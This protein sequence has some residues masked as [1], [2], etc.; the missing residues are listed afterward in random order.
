M[1]VTLPM[2]NHLNEK[3]VRHGW[4]L[5]QRDENYY[6]AKLRTGI[7]SVSVTLTPE[8]IDVYALLAEGNT[9][10][11]TV[12]LVFAELG[13]ASG[14]KKELYSVIGSPEY[15]RVAPGKPQQWTWTFGEIEVTY[16]RL[17][18]IDN[19]RAGYAR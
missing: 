3:L 9:F 16:I 8:T 18:S 5:E 6:S 2:V 13:I 11:D 14:L 19:L 7:Q 10:T 17:P 1:I 12:D 15:V 4:T